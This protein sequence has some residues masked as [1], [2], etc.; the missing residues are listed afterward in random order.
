MRFKQAFARWPASSMRLLRRH[1]LCLA[2]PMLGASI[3]FVMRNKNGQIMCYETGPFRV[4]T[5]V[6]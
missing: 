3:D 4:L 5:T 2:Q 6:R 1:I